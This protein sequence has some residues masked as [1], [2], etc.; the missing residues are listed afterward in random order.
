MDLERA[1]EAYRKGNSARCKLILLK[2]G[3]E[4]KLPLLDAF[5]LLGWGGFLSNPVTA[6]G[7]ALKEAIEVLRAAG[8]GQGKGDGGQDSER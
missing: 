3:E 4:R 8:F 1:L 7:K 2:I 6:Y 5:E